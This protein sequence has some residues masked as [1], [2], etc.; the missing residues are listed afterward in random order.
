MAGELSAFIAFAAERRFEPGRW[1]CGLWLADW[2]L[3][4]TGRDVAAD[5]RGLDPHA[6]R[7]AAQRLPVVMGR[8]MRRCGSPPV[9]VSEAR[10]G[11]IAVLRVDG[12]FVGGIRTGIGWAVLSTKGVACAKALDR[13]VVRAWRI[14]A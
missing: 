2:I 4:R 5:L 7:R 1:D 8:V 14:D 6:W 13:A 3:L 11:D 12:Q 10:A 9:P